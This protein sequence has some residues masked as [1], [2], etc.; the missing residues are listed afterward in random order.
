MAFALFLLPA[1]ATSSPVAVPNARQLEFMELELTQVCM[2]LFVCV[3]EERGRHCQC[4]LYIHAMFF[5]SHEPISVTITT[6]FCQCTSS[7]RASCVMCPVH[8]LWHSNV[9]TPFD[10]R[11]WIA[12]LF[13]LFFFFFF[14]SSLSPPAS[15]SC[16]TPHTTLYSVPVLLP[17]FWSTCSTFCL[18]LRAPCPSRLIL[19]STLP[20]QF[21]GS[22]K[23]LSL[24]SKPYIPRLPHHISSKL[25]SLTVV[26]C[27]EPNHGA[28]Q[29]TFKYGG[30]QILVANL[31]PP[32]PTMVLALPMPRCRAQ[33][34]STMASGHWLDFRATIR[35]HF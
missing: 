22:T 2:Y 4:P 6:F 15:S 11:T 13:S 9:S 25:N 12:Y 26:A 32:R 7:M 27:L 23:G 17:F 34:S 18:C 1:M 8:A 29:L 20:S 19:S 30:R 3:R 10:A 16:T 33:L 5:F 21:L 24:R 28:W 14:F 35:L 31:D